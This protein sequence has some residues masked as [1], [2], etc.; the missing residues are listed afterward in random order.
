MAE[1]GGVSDRGAPLEQ[2]HVPAGGYDSALVEAFVKLEAEP[3]DR[4]DEGPHGRMILRRFA[5]LCRPCW[6]ELQGSGSDFLARDH[7]ERERLWLCSLPLEA[8]GDLVER[9]AWGESA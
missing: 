4:C 2:P 5:W 8:A 3:C 9:W 6:E 1:R 7:E